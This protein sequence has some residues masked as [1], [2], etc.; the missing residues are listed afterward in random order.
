VDESFGGLLNYSEDRYAHISASFRTPFYTSAEIIGTNGR[1]HLN[2]PF[3]GLD[4]E[5]VMTFYP[6]E[7]E[8][9]EIPVPEKELYLGQVQDMHAAILDGSTNHVS[10][11][12]TRNHV[13]TVLALYQAAQG[14]QVV[15]LE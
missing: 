6:K 10:L 12:E 8:P 14:K 15:M 4:G 9:R 1:L 5:R 2:R 11:Q 3:V 7:G 13:K